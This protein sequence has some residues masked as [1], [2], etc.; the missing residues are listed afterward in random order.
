MRETQQRGLESMEQLKSAQR[1][2]I[3]FSSNARIK[4]NSMK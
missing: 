1:T 4:G 2:I 3:H